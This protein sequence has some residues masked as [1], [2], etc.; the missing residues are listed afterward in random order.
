NRAEATGS[1]QYS[2]QSGVH[3]LSN[4]TTNPD[5]DNNGIA[6]ETA[7][8]N[9]TAVSS[10][11]TRAVTL[12]KA[13]T[14]VR[15]TGTPAVGDRINYSFTVKNTGKTPLF[16]VTVTDPLPNLQWVTNTPIPRLDPGAENTNSYSAYYILTQAD[17]DNGRV[18]NTATVTGQWGDSNGTPQNVTAND[19]AVVTALSEPGL[20]LLKEVA[21]T[22]EIGNPRTEPGQQIRY[23][24]TVSNTGNTTLRNVTVT[25]ALAGVTPDPS[26]A[27]AIGE[28]APGALAI[29]YADY[30]VTLADI[31]AGKVD[32]SATASAV[33]GPNTGT[34]IGTPP[35]P[36]STTLYR[37]PRLTLDKQFTGTI[38][39]APRA[40]IPLTWTVTATNTGNVTLSN[41]GVTDL[42]PDAS[43]SPLS[44]ASLLPGANRTFTVSA[45]LRQEDIESGVLDNT[46]TINFR[47]PRGVEDP[48]DARAH[49]VL[50]PQAPSIALT[51]KGDV[52]GLSSPPIAG[53]IITYTIVIRNT[54]NVALRNLVL[55]DLL[56]GVVIDSTPLAGLVL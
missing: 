10:N 50:P 20:T 51:K 28:L 46:A 26:G 21:S 48:I 13:A 36:T 15:T 34:S 25:D 1:G 44:V 3:D 4:N 29:V 39:P 12:D 52:A 42:F 49:V 43:V 35:S 32:N 19:N 9:P 18:P 7:N 54:G 5:P 53:E 16:D 45:S 11:P 40:G 22:D 37:D 31:D 38:P 41:L 24:F 8:N 14:P 33:Y 17:L 2:G 30:A 23:K 6:D 47:S 55:T 27:F 56:P